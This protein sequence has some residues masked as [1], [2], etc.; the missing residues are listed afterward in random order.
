M[1]NFNRFQLGFGTTVVLMLPDRFIVGDVV[2]TTMGSA[3]F[4]LEP[5]SQWRLGNFRHVPSIAL[6][7]SNVGAVKPVKTKG[8]AVH[9]PV[10]LSRL[11]LILI[12]VAPL[13]PLVLFTAGDVK[14]SP[15]IQDNV[16]HRQVPLAA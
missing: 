9:R 6:V 2:F 12:T 8:N 7:R 15:M 1:S 10:A 4:R 5:F 11:T 16:H 13:T 14:T 3:L